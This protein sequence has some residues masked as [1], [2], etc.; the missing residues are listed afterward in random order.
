MASDKQFK[1]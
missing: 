1:D